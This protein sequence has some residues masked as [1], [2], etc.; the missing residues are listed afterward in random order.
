MSDFQNPLLSES[1]RIPFHLIEAQHVEPGVRQVL[2]A[3]QARIDTLAGQDGPRTY[4]NT[5][6]ALDDI[7]RWVEERIA[8][9]SHLLS[10]AETPAFREAYNVVLPEMS[11]FWT[12]L[13][14]NGELWD[15]MKAFARTPEAGRLEGVRRRHL[16]KTLQQF[17]R[18]GADLPADRRQRLEELKVELAQLSQKFSENVLDATVGWER[19]VDD[20]GRL[21]GL[22]PGALSRA[23]AKARDKGVDGWLLTLD[24]PSVEPVL[25][26][27]RDREIRKEV[28]S[29][30]TLR[31]REGELDN[32]PLLLRILTLRHE[33]ARLLGYD[34]FPDYRLEDHMAGSGAHAV[35]FEADLVARTRPYWARDV[36]DLRAHA[37][38]LGLD[39]LRPWDVA[40]VSEDLR[41]KEYDLDDEM[42]R[43][44]FRLEQVMEGLFQV[45]ERVFGFAVEA[46]DIEE[47]WHSDVR[48]FD[49]FECDGTRLGAFYTDWF[50]RK[51][52]R[53]G[54]WMNDFITGGP[55]ADG[56]FE[57]H[58]GVVC[59]NFT[60]PDGDEP[61][62]LT[63][64]EVQTIFHE[65]GHLLH[66]CTSRVPVRGRA[67]INVA[68]DFVEL[69]SQFM[70]NWTWEREA[71]DLF[72]RHWR[73]GEPLPQDLFER[74]IRARR[75]MG[76][77]AQMRQLGFGT[78]DLALHGE[79]A[80]EADGHT[81]EDV[82]AFA[83]ERFLDFSPGPEFADYNILA[84]FTHLFS[85]GYAA[86]YYSYVWSEVLDADAF[87]RFRKEGIFNRE[88]GRAFVDAVLTRG[89]SEAPEE[90]FRAFMDRDPDP[91]ALLERNLGPPPGES[92]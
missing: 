76:G 80:P 33:M 67:G 19:P 81:A 29:G 79:M 82:M 22:P 73:T 2:A 46:V 16:D 89:D 92:E 88:T 51:E 28:F 6:D 26:H 84:S 11:A 15:R 66:H 59:G 10:V 8:P 24:Y 3:G 64:R 17:R 5:L 43:P 52:K 18:A 9:A 31:C 45:V 13:P 44:Y 39:C 50:P 53:Q 83:R 86:S 87:T 65:F 42:L 63:H 75:F 38:T 77:W 48:Y 25:K 40:F 37:H 68:W 78:V 12:R 35:A 34:S 49:L 14:L 27:V 54:A 61:S 1:Y 30:F 70:E 21:D 36:A 41:K 90:L 55:T 71:L 7:T 69:P 47:V 23:R 91:T 57:P 56:G 62:L 4:D 32:R 60:P 74:M 20:V 72:G 85:G 58:L